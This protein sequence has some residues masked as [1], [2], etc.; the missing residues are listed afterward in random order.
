MHLICIGFNT[1]EKQ[2][3]FRCSSADEESLWGMRQGPS[4]K[5]MFVL[6]DYKA[7]IESVSMAFGA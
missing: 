3:H 4:P 2:M 6:V 7:A 5:E 1:R